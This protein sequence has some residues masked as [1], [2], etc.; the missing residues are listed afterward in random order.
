VFSV[1]R[2]LPAG[3]AGIVAR[4]LPEG[5][6]RRHRKLFDLAWGLKALPHLA[7]ADP[8]SLEAVVR[9][10]HE[11]ATP[12]IRTKDWDASWADFL[13]GWSRVRAPEGE[14]LVDSLFR[15]ARDGPLPAAAARFE[16]PEV[17]QLV[18]LC[19]ALQRHAGDEPFFLDC[20]N[21]G[22]LLGVEHTTAWRWL[23]YLERVGVL[24]RVATGSLGSKKANEYRFLS[25]PGG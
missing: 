8:L 17:K 9:K 7:D 3:A 12:F 15:A 19:V 1:L 13:D 2:G 11:L 4:T 14:G 6:G 18:A 24:R 10:W 23:V 5:P 16:S 25:G 22:R 20:R 21:A